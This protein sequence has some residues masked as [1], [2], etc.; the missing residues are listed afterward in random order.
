M[1]WKPAKEDYPVTLLR[2]LT[3]SVVSSWSG[4]VL[5]KA[6]A[7]SILR[8]SGFAGSQRGDYVVGV[9]QTPAAL[10]TWR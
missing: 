1:L 8:T 3:A 6:A 5:G 4:A 7:S 9:R 10:K 2:W